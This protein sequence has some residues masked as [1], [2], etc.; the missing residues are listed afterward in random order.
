MPRCPLYE[1]EVDVEPGSHGLTQP[2]PLQ[3][4]QVQFARLPE[5]PVPVRA[6]EE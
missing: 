5:S 3:P 4:A 2:H 6:T 1:D